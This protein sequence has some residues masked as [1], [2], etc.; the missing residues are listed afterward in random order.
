MLRSFVL[1][2]GLTSEVYT[3]SLS[4]EQPLPRLRCCIR[5][6][7][8]TIP[9]AMAA[10]LTGWHLHV[11]WKGLRIFVDTEGERVV[12]DDNDVVGNLGG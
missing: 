5:H 3:L 10:G 7:I 8:E 4:S 6:F 11:R 2:Q 9:I 12:W 1:R